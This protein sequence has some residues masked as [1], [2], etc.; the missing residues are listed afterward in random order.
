M[1]H[2]TGYVNDNSPFVVRDS[3]T[4]DICQNASQALN[5]LARLAPYMGTTKK[6]VNMN[7][8]F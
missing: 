4:E 6:R 7:E 8:F 2:I 5:S 3:I 1:F